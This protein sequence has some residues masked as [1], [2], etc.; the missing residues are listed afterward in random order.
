M[1]RCYEN[2]SDD[3]HNTCVMKFLVLLH[4]IPLPLGSIG[5]KKARSA[6]PVRTRIFLLDSGG[7]GYSQSGMDAGRLILAL[8]LYFRRGPVS[9]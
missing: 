5:H 3:S 4:G 2:A 8:D 7:S 1:R 6:D 9:Q